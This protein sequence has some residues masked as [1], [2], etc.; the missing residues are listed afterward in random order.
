MIFFSKYES[1]GND[2][3][4]VDDRA[5]LFPHE[6]TSFIQHICHRQMGIGAH[7]LVLLQHAT[8]PGADFRMRI[9]HAD[10]L[11]GTTCDNS[12]RCLVRFLRDLQIDTP[13]TIETHSMVHQC[14]AESGRAQFI[15]EGKLRVALTL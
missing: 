5:A 15:F 8:R 7:G 13:L 11:E 12:L 1:A 10:G 3:I 6:N 2:F 14:P 4:L 9:F